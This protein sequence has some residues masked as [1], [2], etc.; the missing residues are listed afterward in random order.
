MAGGPFG[1][2]GYTG[3]WD[4]RSLASA[5]TGVWLS[6]IY[7]ASKIRTDKKD[8]DCLAIEALELVGPAALL[9]FKLKGYSSEL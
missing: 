9:Q 7:F 4:M 3:E 8:E 2:T 1:E 5:S 6:V